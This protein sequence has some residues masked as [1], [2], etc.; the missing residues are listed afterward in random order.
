MTHV[1][2]RALPPAYGCRSA[3]Q[4]R[5]TLTPDEVE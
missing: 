3:R 1:N 4:R 2:P 5:R